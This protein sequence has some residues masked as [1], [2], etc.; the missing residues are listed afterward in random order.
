M[1]SNF[2]RTL[3]TE[4]VALE[5]LKYDVTT[6]SV[7]IDLIFLNLQVTRTC[8]ISWM[9]LNFDQNGSPTTELAA[10]ECLKSPKSYKGGKQGLQYIFIFIGLF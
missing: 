6:F 4:L 2:D 10:L 8:I 1:N 5:R 9:S 3:T 7:A